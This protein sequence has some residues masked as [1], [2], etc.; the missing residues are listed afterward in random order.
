MKDLR[1]YIGTVLLG[2]AIILTADGLQTSN[3]IAIGVGGAL[4]GVYNV[5]MNDRD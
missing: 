4:L 3:Y 2:V 1:I 5:I